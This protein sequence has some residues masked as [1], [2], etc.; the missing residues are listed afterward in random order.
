M[1]RASSVLI[2]NST[3][4]GSVVLITVDGSCSIRGCHPAAAGFDFVEKLTLLPLLLERLRERKDAFLS[5]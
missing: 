5:E 3:S 2:K 1:Q 4:R